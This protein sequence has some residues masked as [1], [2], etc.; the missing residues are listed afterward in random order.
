MNESSYA[1]FNDSFRMGVTTSAGLSYKIDKEYSITIGGS[2][3]LGNLILKAAVI[4]TNDRAEFGLEGISLNDHEG[5][6]YSN[7]SRERL[8]SR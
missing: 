4:V 6:F 2:Y 7:L 8:L 3:I 1:L 5:Y